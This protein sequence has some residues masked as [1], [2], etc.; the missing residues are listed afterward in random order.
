MGR[1]TKDQGTSE[2]DPGEDAEGDGLVRTYVTGGV[3][4]L[5][6]GW[7]LEHPVEL[8]FPES[9]WHISL[10]SSQFHV[11]LDSPPIQDFAT[12]SNEV[13]SVVQGLLDALG[14]HLATPLRAEVSSLVTQGNTLVIRT[15]TWEELREAPNSPPYVDGSTLQPF[16]EAT[17]SNSFARHALADLRAALEY[18]DD[19]AFYAYRAIET[20]RQSFLA[21]DTDTD[22]SRKKSWQALRDTLNVD[23]E[24]LDQARALATPRRHGE[25]GTLWLSEVQRLQVLTLARVVVRSFIAQLSTADAVASA[26]I[27]PRGTP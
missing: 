19:T 21:G 13:V 9:R 11:L 16:F 2:S 23:R 12:F 1:M 18:P 20:V 7:R 14:F 10:Q 26:A 22:A 24:S 8:T 6:G 3:H 27:F 15:L 17:A 4:P 5:S 25:A